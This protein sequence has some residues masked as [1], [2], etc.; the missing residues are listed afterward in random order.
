MF[1]GLAWAL[2]IRSLVTVC[3]SIFQGEGLGWDLGLGKWI[4]LSFLSIFSCKETLY[5]T[6]LPKTMANKMYSSAFYHC[7]NF[8][9]QNP[10][11]QYF[12]AKNNQYREAEKS[13]YHLKCNC[14]SETSA[15][16]SITNTTPNLL[17]QWKYEYSTWTKCIFIVF[18]DSSFW[19]NGNNRTM[20]KSIPPTSYTEQLFWRVMGRF[21]YCRWT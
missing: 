20:T 16:L 8:R 5:A 21:T 2:R 9:C 13:T 6:Y 17:L 1:R 19:N 11:H 14:S 10:L 12:H 15:S 18:I 4:C 7:Q 3:V